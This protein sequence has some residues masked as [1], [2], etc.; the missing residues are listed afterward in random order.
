MKKEICAFKGE[1][2]ESAYVETQ[3][4][5]WYSRSEPLGA[6]RSFRCGENAWLDMCDRD[7]STD[8]K[9]KEGAKNFISTGGQVDNPK[10]NKSQAGSVTVGYYDP[11]DVPAVNIFASHGCKGSSRRLYA[12]PQTDERTVDYA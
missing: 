9:C 3:K 11:N 6:F 1:E 7:G 10:L 12:N 4:R 8:G 2:S 5:P